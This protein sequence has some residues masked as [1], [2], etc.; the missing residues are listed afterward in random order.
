M[1]K[2]ILPLSIVLAQM[3][4]VSAFAQTKGG[5]A[6]PAGAKAA[7]PSAPG[8]P[9]RVGHLPPHPVA[10]E[11][12]SAGAKA[13]A[14]SAPGTPSHVGHLPPH[15]VAGEADP[16]GAKAAGTAHKTTKAERAA[17]RAKRKAAAAEANK[18]GKIKSG[19][20]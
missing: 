18:S 1:K 13:A 15:P 7:A 11:A 12:D 10:G 8:T 16:A 5:E 14:P 17:A 19:E 6:D 3:L 2:I 20:Q 4:A 9:S